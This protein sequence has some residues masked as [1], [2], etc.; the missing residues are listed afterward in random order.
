MTLDDFTG[1]VILLNVWATW[2]GP[3]VR[4]LASLDRL[5]A[6]LG[7]DK[8]QVVALSEDRGEA[9][10]V[11]PFFKQRQI[12][13]LAPYL[14]MSGVALAALKSQGLPTSILIDRTGQEVGRMLGGADWDSGPARQSLEDIINAP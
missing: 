7:G 5:Q 11:L 4:E 3:C 6:S 1:R 9:A 13:A 8:F 2:C 10:T 12:Q 14:D